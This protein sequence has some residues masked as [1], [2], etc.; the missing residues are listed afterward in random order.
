[1]LHATGSTKLLSLN[2]KTSTSRIQSVI[3][4]SPLAAS[5]IPP[6]PQ[7]SRVQPL[8]IKPVESEHQAPQAPPK[9]DEIHSDS[10][11][12]P[13]VKKSLFRLPATPGSN[14][15]SMIPAEYST[16]EFETR[17]ASY[18]DDEKNNDEPEDVKQKRRESRSD[19]WVD[20]L[21]GS[22][23]RRI[24][25]QDAELVDR[26]RGQNKHTEPDVVA[27]EIAEVLAAVRNRSP[28]PP[29]IMEP[30]GDDG[31]SIEQHLED[32]DIDEVETV[33]RTSNVRSVE[34]DETDSGLPYDESDMGHGSTESGSDA[35]Q[36]L[37]ARQA[38]VQQR[39]LGY[40]DLHP[41][42]RRAV[43]QS[44]VDEDN[45]RAKL[46]KDDS[47]DEQEDE[48]EDERRYGAPDIRPLPIPPVAPAPQAIYEPAPLVP[49]KSMVSNL[50]RSPELNSPGIVF[51][52]N[53]NPLPATPSKT[54][55]LIEMYRERERGTPPK[56]SS[57]SNAV[58]IIVAPLPPSRL[59]VRTTSLAKD[60]I[61]LPH[62]P[63]L[64]TSSPKPSPPQSTLID[65]PRIPLEETGR[66]SPGRYQHGAPLHN[67]IEEEEE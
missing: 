9:S 33:P 64:A 44:V 15:R 42:R 53:G 10:T 6:V 30:V 62:P 55:A 23:S 18:S 8:P 2:T 34:T 19:A 51:P 40:F 31:Y 28:S 21:V 60:S 11:A 25:G 24:G 17:M 38:A 67:V 3:A 54:A 14:R 46:S 20:I 7:V 26:K 27:D 58:P 61:P 37:S 4:P 36:G 59:P 43:T 12:S 50:N 1:M 48:Q 45:I 57:P 5:P 39:R 65:L 47:D 29:S 32:L 13:S 35:H 52:T 63:I 66:A 16:V 41:D 22:Q 56:T 49:S